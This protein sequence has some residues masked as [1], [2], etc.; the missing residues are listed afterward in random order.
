MA[1]KTRKKH[2]GLQAWGQ[3]PALPQQGRLHTQL[4]SPGHSRSHSLWATVANYEPV[5]L[6]T[7]TPMN[8]TTDGCSRDTYKINNLTCRRDSFNISLFSH[9]LP[10]L[11]QGSGGHDPGNLECSID[12]RHSSTPGGDTSDRKATGSYQWPQRHKQGQ[13]HQAT[14]LVETVK[15]ENGWFPYIAR[16]SSSKRNQSLCYVMPS[17]EK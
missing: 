2:L 17:T 16:S 1:A 5:P 7:E 11:S 6:A 13:G 14:P 10:P 12:P 4:W 8:P 9:P 15:I 3:I